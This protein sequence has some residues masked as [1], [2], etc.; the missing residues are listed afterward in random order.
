[1]NVTPH[2]GV[3]LGLQAG[4]AVMVALMAVTGSKAHA[5]DT[6]WRADPTDTVQVSRGEKVYQRF[7]SLCH[8]KN[9]Q[10]QSDWRERGPNGKMPAP[11]HDESGHTWHHSDDMLFGIIKFGLVPPYAP[12]NY[13]TDMPGWGETLQD[14]DIAAVLAFLKSRWPERE[15]GFQ[16]KVTRDARASK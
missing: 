9:L 12:R 5:A 16:E 6:P 2:A 1:M 3:G 7:C 11:P 8:G 13:E 14:E 15:R 4:L 10:G